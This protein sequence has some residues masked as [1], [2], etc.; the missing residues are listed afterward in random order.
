M[1]LCNTHLSII[2][3]KEENDA[4]YRPCEQKPSSSCDI[5]LRV[6]K[7]DEN[8][9]CSPIHDDFTLKRSLESSLILKL[10]RENKISSTMA[11]FQIHENGS[12][13]QS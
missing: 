2:I 7:I 5:K 8:I 13:I 4:D 6:D 10:S 11:D 12:E 9:V 1:N 3:K